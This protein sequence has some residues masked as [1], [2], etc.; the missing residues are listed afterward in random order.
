VKKLFVTTVSILLLILTWLALD[1]IMTGSESSRL[2]E[3][4][5]VAVTVVWFGV[6]A[7]R[8]IR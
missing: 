3:W 4:L 8:L 1:D 7:I 6:V 5:V 2:L